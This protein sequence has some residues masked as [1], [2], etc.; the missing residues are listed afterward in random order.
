MMIDLNEPSL[1]VESINISVELGAPFLHARD[2]Q[3]HQHLEEE[4][5]ESLD[6]NVGSNTTHVPNNRVAA[7]PPPANALVHVALIRLQ[8]IY[9]F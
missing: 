1:D 5:G 3:E 6:P 9:N 4:V 2:E 7:P 8:R